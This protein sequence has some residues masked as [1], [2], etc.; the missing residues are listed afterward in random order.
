MYLQKRR[1]FANDE[2]EDQ[3]QD[4]HTPGEVEVTP[5]ASDLL[6]ET[7]EVAQ[8]VAEATGEDVDVSTDEESG[9]VSF[10]VGDKVLTV[11]PE[12]DEE[13]LQSVKVP[14]KRTVRASAKKVN[15]KTVK[16]GTATKRRVVRKAK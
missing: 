16:A 14:K 2:I 3:V 4:V 12:G 6:F 15:K 1:I 11:V 10:E 7:E 5:E 13:I 9:E 8:L